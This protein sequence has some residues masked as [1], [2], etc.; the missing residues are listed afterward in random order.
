M[1]DLR[2]IWY[3]TLNDLTTDDQLI[4]QTYHIIK[5]HYS[6][7]YR[8]YHNLDHLKNMFAILEQSQNSQ[9]STPLNLAI[10]CHDLIYNPRFHDNEYHS[11]VLGRRLIKLLG[12]SLILRQR[13]GEMIM[14]TIDHRSDDLETQILLDCDLAILGSDVQQYQNYLKNIR[15]EYYW[16]NGDQWRVGRKKVVEHF[17]NMDQIFYQLNLE[18]VAR[19]NLS[20]ELN[21]L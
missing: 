20:I 3:Q 6:R 18:S 14:A 8:A 11:M 1:T 12:G 16:L 10:F 15:S 4:D 2:A 13:V 19:E 9:Q 17:L 5:Y 7:V 21:N